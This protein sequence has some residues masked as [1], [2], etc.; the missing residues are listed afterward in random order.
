MFGIHDLRVW[1]IDGSRVIATA[2]A[3][4]AQ[5]AGFDR[6]YT[7]FR[8]YCIGVVFMRLAFSQKLYQGCLHMRILKVYLTCVLI[9]CAVI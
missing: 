4:I 3:S 9:L 8:H 2:H 6:S 7:I 1:Q 5:S